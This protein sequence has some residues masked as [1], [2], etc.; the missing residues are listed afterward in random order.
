MVSKKVV[1]EVVHQLSEV[2][3]D[4][5]GKL[6]CE[7][8]LLLEGCPP[9]RVRRPPV[10]SDRLGRATGKRTEENASWG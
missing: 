10:E 5:R 6:Y 3:Y 7:V 1:L 8:V 4:V 2:Q 9:F